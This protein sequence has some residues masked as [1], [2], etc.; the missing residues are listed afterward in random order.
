MKLSFFFPIPVYQQKFA[1]TNLISTKVH[2]LDAERKNFIQENTLQ[3]RETQPRVK[4]KCAPLRQ[5]GDYIL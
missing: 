4:N 5:R 1:T 3:T 2:N